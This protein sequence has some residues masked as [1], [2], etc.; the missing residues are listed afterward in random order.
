MKAATHRLTRRY[1]RTFARAFTGRVLIATTALAFL[2]A[3]AFLVEQ[4]LVQRAR[5]IDEARGHV[6]TVAAAFA[7]YLQ[8]SI[9]SADTTVNHVIEH[10]IVGQLATPTGREALNTMLHSHT[11]A[12]KEAFHVTILDKEGK[13]VASS[14]GESFIGAD[15]S[16][17]SNFTAV[18]GR[19]D[20]ARHLVSG[21]GRLGTARGN[22][23]LA[24]SRPY[25]D[26]TGAFAGVIYMAF[27]VADIE[28]FFND[29]KFDGVVFA[30]I[31][32]SDDTVL[33]ELPERAA[34]VTDP[35][36]ESRAVS[37]NEAMVFV[38]LDRAALL[39][40]WLRYHAIVLGFFALLG[41]VIAAITR[42]AITLQ[43]RR[44]KAAE[45]ATLQVERLAQAYLI[46]SKL[47]S[48]ALMIQY[49]CDAARAI[50]SCAHAVI[51]L[52]GGD[53]SPVIQ[54]LS[55]PGKFLGAGVGEIR[56]WPEE[57]KR[58][59]DPNESVR[60]GLEALSGYSGA[61]S[62]VTSWMALPLIAPDLTNLGTLEVFNREAGDFTAE[63]QA[64]GVQWAQLVSVA[65]FKF[66]LIESQRLLN[67]Q[68]MSALER[69][70]NARAEVE[71]I[72]SRISEG[73]CTF[74]RAWRFTYINEAARQ[75]F[76]GI[77]LGVGRT[78]WDIFPRSRH[79]LTHAEF[80]EAVRRN[81]P[82]FYEVFSTDLGKWLEVRV[83]PNP[84]GLSVFFRDAT[85]RRKVAMQL[86]QAQRM[87]T[88][89]QLSGGIAHDFNNL[90]TVVIGNADNLI[91]TAAP[92]SDL[93]D[94]LDLIRMAGRRGA[95]LT[96]RLLAFARRQTLEPA[97]VDILQTISDIKGLVQRAVGESVSVQVALKPGLWRAMVDP[98]QLE[99]AVLN[100]AI[101]ARD[102]MPGGGKLT[103]EARNITVDE[104][105]A[106]N[107]EMKPGAYVLLA[108]ADTGSGMTAEVLARAFEPFFTTKGVGKGTGLG[109]SM[110]YGLV[111]QSGGLVKL[112]S[113]L[114]QG[115]TVKL[116]LPR[117]PGEG[118]APSQRDLAA[119][120]IEGGSEKILLVEDNDL[121][122]AHTRA[123]L[124]AL[125]YTVAA[126][127][128]AAEA[129]AL[130]EGGWEPALL[131][132][133]VVLPGGT[134]GRELAE[135]LMKAGR[136]DRVLY[137]SGYTEDA[138][139]HHGRLTNGVL[140]LSKPFGRRDLARKIREALERPVGGEKA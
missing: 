129:V 137:I 75:I 109:L 58:A 5:L 135:Q 106:L 108:V 138:A 97:A 9:E 110:V 18:R 92:G 103:F 84:D 63:D 91:E 125:G 35:I 66:Q 73:F 120:D 41:A 102:A 121:V 88:V 7:N 53:Q 128:D 94:G 47:E 10:D 46:V 51:S 116:Y 16:D 86:Q 100:L 12:T 71:G 60:L 20:R 101:N 98:V 69:E 89:G 31:L 78:F 134:N 77:E 28:R 123:Q 52:R 8:K 80:S 36:V 85:E 64:I 49:A 57:Q 48:Q 124:E 62:G 119:Q 76:S 11:A 127:A 99:S 70:S 40:P 113:E 122:R 21:R 81:E 83:F 44:E 104:S 50:F 96:Q 115:T 140:L 42:Y 118:T 95:E 3:A 131:L 90:L 26:R 107:D 54:A 87:E 22:K 45:A 59:L 56:F 74:D 133:D 27:S 136:I 43:E 39:A 68:T 14:A 93:Y 33:L 37:G 72:L 132:T 112:Y 1:S 30:S 65:L 105:H 130:I 15:L 82:R 29:V 126:A 4:A 23:V 139:L 34:N 19:P 6:A 38:A 55:P 67:K 114:G 61:P 32:R 24:V 111:K 25:F 117:A 17:Q 79:G 2:T 13:V